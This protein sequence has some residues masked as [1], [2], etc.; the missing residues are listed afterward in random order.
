MTDAKQEAPSLTLDRIGQ[1][2]FT[3]CDL[4][5]ATDFYR[6][7]LGMRFLF[8]AS[9]LSFF[10]CGG[11]R[12]LLGIPEARSSAAPRHGTPRRESGTV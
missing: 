5:R 10:D 4:D 2:A 7:A 8:R 6:N 12:L 11:V 9:G 3:V 1:V